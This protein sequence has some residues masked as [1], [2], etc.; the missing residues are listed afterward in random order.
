[1]ARAQRDSPFLQ[2]HLLPQQASPLRYGFL[3]GPEHPFHQAMSSTGKS[4]AF[5]RT[6]PD[7]R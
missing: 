4:S 5:F 6:S 2:K 7:G 3:F 1:M